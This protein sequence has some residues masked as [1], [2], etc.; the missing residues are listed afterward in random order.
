MRESPR[1]TFKAVDI[2]EGTKPIETSFK[3]WS[4]DAK[5]G[6]YIGSGDTVMSIGINLHTALAAS[7]FFSYENDTTFQKTLDNNVGSIDPHYLPEGCQ[8]FYDTNKM[9]T[10]L[11]LESLIDAGHLRRTDKNFQLLE[12]FFQFFDNKTGKFRFDE[13]VGD[14]ILMYFPQL[15]VEDFKELSQAMADPLSFA[16]KRR[17]VT[18]EE[19]LQKFISDQYTKSYEMGQEALAY[20]QQTG[21]RL[22]L[23]NSDEA[24]S[25]KPLLFKDITEA[26][27][28]YRMVPDGVRG[29]YYSS[30][31]GENALDIFPS[32]RP[33]I[34]NPHHAE[35]LI[36][37][38]DFF[39][40]H[41]GQ[42]NLPEPQR[43]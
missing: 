6:A 24:L 36:T 5:V 4:P 12:Q 23:I 42:I 2:F 18:P 21:I 9:L 22:R 8:Y 34:G 25:A 19:A 17:K 30:D 16:E 20:E 43:K 3:P 7:Q 26:V 13:T 14:R 40:L 28:V 35:W 29:H 41:Y 1:I 27:F 37:T 11:L 10:E 33:K 39:S 32:E 38:Q 31:R 15:R